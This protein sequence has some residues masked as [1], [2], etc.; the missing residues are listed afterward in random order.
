MKDSSIRLCSVENNSFND[1]KLISLETFCE[2][3]RDISIFNS[4]NNHFLVYVHFQLNLQEFIAL[5]NRL[6]NISVKSLDMN[7]LSTT[8]DFLTINKVVL[9]L[10]SSFSFFIDNA[11]AHIKRHFGKD[12][13]E[14]KNLIRILHSNFEN[15]FSYRFLY[16]LRNYSLHLGFPIKMIPFEAIED[17]INPQNMI[18]NFKFVTSKDNLLKEKDLIGRIVTGDLTA[19]TDDDIDIIPLV[20]RLGALLFII[21]RHIYSMFQRQLEESISNLK[22]FAGSY[23]SLNNEVSILYNTKAEGNYIKGEI[24]TIPFIEI[25]EVEKFKN[26]KV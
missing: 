15:H 22:Q 18:G 14:S 7:K 16:K 5:K 3:E 11:Q 20:I 17:Q 6:S 24:L 25:A 1:I 10:L 8:R 4:Y 23:K 9:N 13:N 12:S 26:L 19:M 2:V 21:E